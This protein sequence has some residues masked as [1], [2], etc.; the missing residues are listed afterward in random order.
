M[1]PVTALTS[2]Y[3]VAFIIL[4]TIWI[5]GIME[6]TPAAQALLAEA[7]A[8]YHTPDAAAARERIAARAKAELAEKEA[9]IMRRRQEWGDLEL[10]I[11]HRDGT[12]GVVST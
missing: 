6:P 5:R 8:A 1:G 7:S 9:I 3:A 4:L 10:D 12:D 11:L 2:V